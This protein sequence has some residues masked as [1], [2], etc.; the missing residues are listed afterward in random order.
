[1]AT[2][3]RQVT[4]VRDGMHNGFTDLQFWQGCYW[5]GYRKGSAHA[6]MDGTATVSVS[7]DR[8]R[9][10]EAAR[11]RA[12]GDNRD[13][14]LLPVNEDRMAAYF[15]S[16]TLG[17]G[18]HELQQYLA[19]TDNGFDWTRPEPILEPG[20]W[21]WRIRCHEKRYYG[22]IQNLQGDWSN[23]AAPHQLDLAVS[24]DL[25]NWKILARVGEV[26]GLNESDIFWHPDG[27][28]WM[29]ARSVVRPKGSFFCSARAPYVDWKVVELEPMVHA[30]IFLH[31]AGDLYVAGRCLPPSAGNPVF[32]FGGSS[33]GIWRVRR[34]TLEPVLH[35]PATGD[36]SYP[37]WI[38]DPEGN[39]CL[40]YYSQ[41]AYHLGVEAFS[42]AAGMP[43]DVY[44]AELEL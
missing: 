30:P 12:R 34:E 15:P 4:V 27:E 35:I 7:A 2:M 44:F 33:L 32:P 41:H 38:K 1:M 24:D 28:A 11:L 20:L 5:V 16:W 6:S 17:A 14:K 42:S 22:L 9:F 40:T 8:V 26:H 19:F 10:R 29:V 43:D 18:A 37:G 36:C 31:H 39:I 21:L 13:P 25:F 3:R 23:G